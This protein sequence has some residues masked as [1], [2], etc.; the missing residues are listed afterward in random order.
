MGRVL[1]LVTGRGAKG[2][3]SFIKIPTPNTNLGQ[4]ERSAASNNTTNSSTLQ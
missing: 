3:H 4:E 1:P 2:G